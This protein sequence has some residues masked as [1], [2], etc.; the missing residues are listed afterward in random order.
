MPLL[1][2]VDTALL[3]HLDAAHYLG[4]VAIGANFIGLMYWSFGF[5]RMGTTGLIAQAFGRHWQDRNESNKTNFQNEIDAVL[6]R[7]LIIG[8]VLGTAVL[9][10]T[11]LISEQVV[12]WMQASEKIAPRAKEYIDIRRYSAPAVFMAFAISGWLVGS[13]QPRRALALVVV[14][15]M[16]NVVLDIV[17]IVYLNWQS[18]GAAWATLIAEYLGLMLGVYFLTQHSSVFNRAQWRQWLAP[19]LVKKM[20]VVNYYLLIRTLILMLVFNFFTAQGAAFGDI[21]LAANAILLQLFLFSVFVMDG[22]SYAAEALCGEA[23]GAKRASRFKQY[24][25]L[26]GMRELQ[27][28]IGFGALFAVLGAP[29]LA[30]LTDVYAVLETASQYKGWI[31]ILPL[32]GC[33]AYLLDGVS[34]GAG[35]TRAMYHSMLIATLGVFFP[36]WFLT[37]SS[38]GN[39]GLWLAFLCF[40]LARGIYLT[41]Y[42][43]RAELPNTR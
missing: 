3:G 34:I 1:G 31:I 28:A 38:W 2:L 16:I 18:A 9:F 35:K 11:P 10:I 19:T 7:A 4:A 24:I 30:L 26:C 33:L 23:Y 27:T 39:H 21:T 41:W 29:I 5:L 37:K 12:S 15:N 36:I 42:W 25:K 32:A 14:T 43:A 17:F 40:N 8:V 22:F 6:F 13:Q 20:L